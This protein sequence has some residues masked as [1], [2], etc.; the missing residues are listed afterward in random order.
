M[1]E[2]DRFESSRGVSF[3]RPE[4][5]SSCEFCTETAF[6]RGLLRSGWRVLH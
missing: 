4:L 1:A 5:L 2:R 3:W 6:T